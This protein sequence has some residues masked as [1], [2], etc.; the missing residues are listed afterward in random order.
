MPKGHPGITLIKCHCPVCG[1]EF[2]VR[3]GNEKNN[4]TCSVA[5]GQKLRVAQVTGGARKKSGTQVCECCGKEFKVFASQVKRGVK[6]CS[7][8]CSDTSMYLRVS[9]KCEA[10]GKD[11]EVAKFRAT[12][13]RFCCVKCAKSVLSQDR[14]KRVILQ[15]QCCGKDM[16]VQICRVDRTK[17]C[18]KECAFKV[19]K[20][21][22]SPHWK[23]VGVYEYVLNADG[24]EIKRKSRAVGCAKTAKRNAEVDRA[25]SKW[26]DL[27][28]IKSIY[29]LAE[30]ITKATGMQHH[31]DHIVPLHGKTVSGLHNEFNLQILTATE[32][33]KKHNKYWPDK[34]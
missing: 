10:C 17:F 28:K 29:R 30:K 9:K 34:P 1:A 23:G 8:A 22:G 25:T 5:C 31:V 4:R 6:Y 26:A 19:M 13:A 33:L 20:G 27:D 18:S 7:K 15:C 11:F 32:N 14:K 21:E 16:E 12:E 2:S 3:K 24:Q